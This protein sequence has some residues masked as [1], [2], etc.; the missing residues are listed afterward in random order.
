MNSALVTWVRTFESDGGGGLTYAALADG[1]FLYDVMLHLDPREVCGRQV[2]RHPTD[3]AARLANLAALLQHIK[4]FYQEVLTQTV[5]LR[6]PDVVKLS[7]AGESPAGVQELRHLL[8]LVLGCAVQSPRK[9]DIIDNIKKLDLDT[10]HCIVEC[11]KEVTDNPEA[12][13]PTEWTQVDAVPEDQVAHVFTTLVQQCRRL[14]HERDTYNQ[15]LLKVLCGE[16]DEEETSQESVH[17]LGVQL[18]DCKAQLRRLRQEYEE[19]AES[20]AEYKDELD[21]TKIVVGKLRQ[22]NVELVQDA[23]AARA[24]R[25]EADILRERASRVDAL[26]QEVARYRDKMADIEFYKTRV[27]E[28]REDNRILVETKEML[29]E[30]LASSRRRAEQVLDLENNILQLKQTINQITIVSTT[31]YFKHI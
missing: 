14:A 28:L 11:I 13:W 23:R 18:A 20:L 19:K 4:T 1:V 22:E 7:R 15:E 9:E 21:Q 10:Q 17:H 6:L 16:G 3:P 27:E 26:E 29:E 31:Y 30:Q 12:V 5:V 2:N 8:L 24:W 25:D